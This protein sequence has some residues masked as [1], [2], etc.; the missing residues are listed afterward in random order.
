MKIWLARPISGLFIILAFG[1]FFFD[2]PCSCARELISLKSGFQIEA[3]SHQ[4]IDGVITLQ[5]AT[6]TL[7]FQSSEVAGIETVPRIPV[8]VAAAPPAPQP[9]T[10]EEIV[11]KASE[12]QGT[13]IEFT[14]LVLSV[15]KVE[16]G[17]K[18]TAI[19]PKGAE[20]LMQLMPQTAAVLGVDARKAE[21]NA[22][23]GAAYLRELLDRYRHNAVLALAAYNAGPAAVQKYGGVPP[24]PETQ[25]Y[26]ERVLR[27]YSRMERQRLSQKEYQTSV[28]PA[29]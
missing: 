3:D 11:R 5:L 12:S 22:L 14:E 6:G 21:Q 13:A 17:L 23:G 27:E 18:Q 24:Y 29:P 28:R 8:P 19:S 26:I 15:A 10:P 9:S 25:Q 7:Q 1:A 2:A 4:E 20:G 16:S